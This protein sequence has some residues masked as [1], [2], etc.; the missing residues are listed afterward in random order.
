MIHRHISIYLSR[1]IHYEELA[2]MIMEA[3]KPHPCRVLAADP[4]EPGQSKS[5][6]LGTREADGVNLGL[7]AEDHVSAQVVR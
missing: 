5:E 7:R 3:E 6:G 2:Y 4:G 1:A